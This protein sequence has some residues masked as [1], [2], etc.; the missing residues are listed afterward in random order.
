MILDY[1]NIRA[2]TKIFLHYEYKRKSDPCCV[3][4]AEQHLHRMFRKTRVAHIQKTDR[5]LH[6]ARLGRLQV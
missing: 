5:Y 1:I 3:K 6:D 4:C 2:K